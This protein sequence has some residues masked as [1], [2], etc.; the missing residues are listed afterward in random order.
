MSFDSHR[1]YVGG[2]C[3]LAGARGLSGALYWNVRLKVILVVGHIGVHYFDV[4]LVMEGSEN[5]H[6][7]ARSVVMS[8]HLGCAMCIRC[9]GLHMCNA[10]GTFFF[11]SSLFVYWT[12]CIGF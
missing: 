10:F 11:M 6:V 7:I 5:H 2:R 9:I 4:I 8:V 12:G 3:A 1:R